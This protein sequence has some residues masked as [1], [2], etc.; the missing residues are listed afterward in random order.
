MSWNI[1]LARPGDAAAMPEIE[2]AAGRLFRDQPG[3]GPAGTH[4]LSEAGQRACIARGHCLVAETR[5]RIVGFL[6]TRPHGRELAIVELDVT[7]AW[8]RRGIGIA[9]MRGCGIDAANSG[10][11]AL[12][13]TTFRHIPWNAP[14]YE[15]LGFVEVEDLAA[16]PRLAAELE[17]EAEHGLPMENRVA[18]IRFLV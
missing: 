3:T 8:Q 17:R 5:G 18:M 9:L 10:F 7:P 4:A 15:R 16:N 6:T 1:R 12:T 13:L 14:F 2:L 11:S